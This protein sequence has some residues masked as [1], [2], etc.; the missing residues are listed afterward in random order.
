MDVF[1]DFAFLVMDLLHRGLAAQANALLGSYLGCTGDFEG[2]T[3]L[4]L[5]LGIRAAIRSM[6]AVQTMS[7]E[8][9][10]ETAR[11][12]R[13]YLDDAIGYLAPRPAHLVAVAGVSGTG[14]TTVSALLAPGIGRP[15]GAVHLRSD[16]ERK[17]MFGVEPLEKLPEAAYRPE[18]S[19]A[20]YDRLL[21]RAE[22][23]LAAGQS[24]IVD[25]TFLAEAER[26]AFPALARRLD[27]PFT[28]IWLTADPAVLEARV[29]ARTGDASDADVAV[30]RAQLARGVGAGSWAAVDASGPPEA[31]TAR[32]QALL[33]DG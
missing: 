2:L 27:V 28:G 31:V 22:A 29:A 19:R 6:V 18:A 4:P 8:I 26:A 33:D 9:G 20:V 15:P 1:Y 17:A 11:E 25:A 24:A 12:A 7:G 13:A 21:E 23:C 3:A 10:D 30:L 32:V 16:L 5:F 14:K